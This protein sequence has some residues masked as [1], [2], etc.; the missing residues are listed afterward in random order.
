VRRLIRRLLGSCLTSLAG[1]GARSEEGTTPVTEWEERRDRAILVVDDEA[2]LRRC[3]RDVLELEG[4]R[5]L[6]A[7][8]GRR[9][10]DTLP[11]LPRSAVIILDLMM[12]VMNGFEFVEELRRGAYRDLP[13]IVVSAFS[14]R[15][16]DLDVEA[17]VS[18]PIRPTELF[19]VLGRVERRV[20]R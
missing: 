11:I 17:L 14:D 10:L 2:D 6:L 13:V 3:F 15:A 12:P 1:A 4:Y 20:V 18:K 19:D 8:N 9:A 5:V 7:E 16:A